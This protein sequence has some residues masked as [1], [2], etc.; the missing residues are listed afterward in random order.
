MKLAG[1]AA[2]TRLV[3]VSGDIVE[4]I[5]VSADGESARVRYAE[6]LGAAAAVAGSEATVGAHEII[7]VDGNRFVGP[8]QT[9]SSAG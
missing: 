9:A 7:T 8:G 3:T 5:E 1:L 6:V 4:V 2:G